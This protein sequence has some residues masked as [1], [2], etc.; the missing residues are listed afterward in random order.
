MQ[1]VVEDSVDQNLGGIKM[2]RALCISLAGV[3]VFAVVAVSPASAAPANLAAPAWYT[4]QPGDTI[5]SI[6]RL[7]GVNPW[8]IAAAN[9]LANPNLI[10]AGQALYI[11]GYY[12]N[13][14]PGCGSYYVV[15]I[16]DTLF[17]IAHVYGLNPWTLASVNG[18]Y[19]LN[20]IYA[21]QALFLPCY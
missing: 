20:L 2:K 18:L 16:G 5:F 12:G 13:P 10:Y 6:G 14:G 7:Y 8:T 19:D 15:R 21:G 3:L 4:V 17:G 11:P 1:A 9:R